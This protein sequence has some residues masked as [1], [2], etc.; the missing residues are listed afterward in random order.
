MQQTSPET[1][2]PSAAP[3]IFLALLF[4]FFPLGVGVAL[5][6]HL[7]L[8]PLGEFGA[9]PLFFRVMGSLIALAFVAFGGMLVYG[10]LRLQR[11][12]SLGGGVAALLRRGVEA[13]GGA[14]RYECPRCGAPLAGSADVSPS[15]D[16]K[17]QHC[18]SWFNVHTDS[19]DSP[20][21][22]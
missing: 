9:P 10:A 4:T 13:T 5:L 21:E 11:P 7:W 1:D 20:R 18:G 3:R 6:V 8:T 12:G 19:T 2:R 16:A 15:G 14:R 17:C 22:A